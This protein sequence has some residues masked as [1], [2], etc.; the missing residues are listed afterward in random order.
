MKVI[1]HFKTH[2]GDTYKIVSQKRIRNGGY[3]CFGLCDP[4]DDE[5]AIIRISQGMSNYDLMG[6]II[7]EM[8]HAFFYERSETN[9]TRFTQSVMTLL[10]R[11]QLTPNDRR[12]SRRPKITK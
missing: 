7:H 10:R 1:H 5:E 8:A 2:R 4:P 6:T 3:D 11:L 9:V 12:Y